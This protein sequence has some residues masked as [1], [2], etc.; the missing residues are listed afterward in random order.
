MF[1]ITRNH[2]LFFRVALHFVSD[3]QENFSSSTSLL[4][5]GI[6]SLLMLDN[7]DILRQKNR[8]SKMGVSSGRS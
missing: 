3:M 8:I 2:Q 1:N 7:S 5:F 6:I 4:T